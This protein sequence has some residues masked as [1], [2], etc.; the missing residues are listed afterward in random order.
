MFF[1]IARNAGLRVD[2]MVAIENWLCR[3]LF[4]F[5]GA[6]FWLL[7]IICKTVW[8]WLYRTNPNRMVLVVSIM[9]GIGLNEDTFVASL[10]Q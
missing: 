2:P 8:F 6:E 5:R 1:K 7:F 9:L 10:Y 3:L 4:S